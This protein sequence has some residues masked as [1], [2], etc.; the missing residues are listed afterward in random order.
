MKKYD[1]KLLSRAYDD[2]DDI[3]SHVARELA[4]PETAKQL[5]DTLEDAIL[6][7]EQF[8]QRGSKRK[9]GA[10]A[11]RGYRQLFVKNFVIV[12]RVEESEGRVLIVTVRNVKAK[13]GA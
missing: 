13:I 12:Y 6:S 9:T 8:P 1:V 10:Y 2:L 7:L 3:Y 5:I 11:R 4:V